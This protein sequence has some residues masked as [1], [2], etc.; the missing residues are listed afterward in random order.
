MSINAYKTKVQA[1]RHGF[2]SIER[3]VFALASMTV[4][5]RVC[6]NSVTKWTLGAIWGFLCDDLHHFYAL[7]DQG[8]ALQRN[9]QLSVLIDLNLSLIH[10]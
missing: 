5:C 10:I 6:T 1:A 7:N 2:H 3:H 9:R 4:I 8:I